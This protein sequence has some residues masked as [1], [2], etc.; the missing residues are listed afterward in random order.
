M[1]FVVR[2]GAYA[3]QFVHDS[4]VVLRRLFSVSKISPEYF[5]PSERREWQQTDEEETCLRGMKWSRA[6]RRG[7]SGDKPV[8]NLA[9]TNK[10]PS[11]SK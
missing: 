11:T 3:S 9:L 7:L 1:W 4:A 6:V 5:Q 2:P 8:M 10:Q